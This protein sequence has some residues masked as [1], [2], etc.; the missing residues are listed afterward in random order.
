MK[1]A[2][3]TPYHQIDD[4]LTQCIESV[5]QQDHGDVVHI[6]IADGCP[7]VDHTGYDNVLVI[8]LPRNIADYGDTPRSIGTAYAASLNVDAV[9][10]LDSDNWYEADHISSLVGLAKSSGQPL[11]TSRRNLCHVNGKKMAVC[12]ISDGL[13]FSDTNCLF[14]TRKLFRQAASWWDMPEDLHAIGDRIIWD[15]LLHSA[16]GLASTNKATINYRTRFI[17]HYK[18]AGEDIPEGCKTGE[19]IAQFAEQVLQL[20]ARARKRLESFQRH[21]SQVL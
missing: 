16:P 9:C 7:S 10:Y 19:D 5:Q 11:L 21:E 17:F 4:E 6:L 12:T 2:V 1:V 14:V 18:Q 15:R 8:P 20:K 13:S 3:I